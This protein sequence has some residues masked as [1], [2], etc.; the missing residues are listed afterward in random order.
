METIQV[1]SYVV[2]GLTVG[3]GFNLLPLLSENPAEFQKQLVLQT[4]SLNGQPITN[5]SMAQIVPYLGDLIKA[6]M[7][8]NGLDS[9][10]DESVTSLIAEATGNAE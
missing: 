1:G 3:Q 5:E 4:V 7:K 10:E 9:G 8:V 6:S 2:T